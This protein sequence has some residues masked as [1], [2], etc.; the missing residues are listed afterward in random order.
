MPISLWKINKALELEGISLDG[1]GVSLDHRRTSL[2]AVVNYHE[3]A[4]KIKNPPKKPPVRKV[5]GF[6]D[7]DNPKALSNAVKSVRKAIASSLEYRRRVEELLSDKNEEDA[8]RDAWVD[9]IYNVLVEEEFIYESSD[10]SMWYAETFR[11][12]A[13]KDALRGLWEKRVK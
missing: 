5:Y 12:D 10:G 11:G 7:G 6:S 4:W 1:T 9:H 13:I 2:V 8:V 3:D